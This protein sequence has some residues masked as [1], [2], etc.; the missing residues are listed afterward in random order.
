MKAL[1]V[2]DFQRGFLEIDDFSL[3]K[4]KVESL[5]KDFNRNKQPVIFIRHKDEN[6][7]SPIA[8]GSE[9]GNIDSDLV[10]YADN[11]IE[12]ITPSA[13]FKTNLNEVLLSFYVNHIFVTGFNTEFC[14]QFTAIAAYDRGYHVTSI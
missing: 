5:I 12:N 8:D 10:K 9:G 1:L 13:L 7:E 2:I 14:P 4:K 6:S 3:E 11:I